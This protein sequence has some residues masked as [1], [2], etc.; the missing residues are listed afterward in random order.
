MKIKY[1]RFDPEARIPERGHYNDVGADVFA[2]E[3]YLMEAYSTLKIPLGF[4]L[5]VPDGYMA[6]LYTR[7]S[8]AAKG[9]ACEMPPID[10]GYRGEIH[11]MLT[12]HNRSPYRIRKGDKIGQLVISP[13][14]YAEFTEDL[15]RERGEDAFGST[16][17]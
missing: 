5:A 8:M 2:Q 16:G 12:N 4:G 14:V 10:P 11:C 17:R 3:D 6:N 9:V 15:G 1:I 7:S 13:I